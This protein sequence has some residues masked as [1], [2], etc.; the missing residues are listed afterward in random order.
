MELRNHIEV[1]FP[2]IQMKT[3][4]V[5]FGKVFRN[6]ML[7]AQRGVADSSVNPASMRFLDALAS[8]LS[9]VVLP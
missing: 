1:A 2:I 6:F 8:H 9:S 7:I 5:L 3:T 4:L